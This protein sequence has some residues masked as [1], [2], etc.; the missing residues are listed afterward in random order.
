[1]VYLFQQEGIVFYKYFKG[2]LR[3]FYFTKGK[4]GNFAV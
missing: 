4:F 2:K 3:K 1:M